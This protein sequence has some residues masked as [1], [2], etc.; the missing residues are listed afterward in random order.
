MNPETNWDD[1]EPL[2]DQ[3]LAALPDRYRV[4]IVLCDLEGRPRAEAA[5]ALRCSEGTLSSRLTRGRRLLADRLKRRGVRLSAGALTALLT[6]QSAALAEPLIRATLPV[7][8]S[9]G[10]PAG[11]SAAASVSPNV[12]HLATGVMKSMFLKKLQT[13][14]FAAF[15]VAALAVAGAVSFPGAEAAPVPKTPAAPPID[16][17]ALAEALAD[18][19]GNLLMHRKVFKE[20]KCDFDQFDK[21][22]D[23]LEDAQEKGAQ[24]TNEILN[25]IR[26][27]A[28]GAANPDAAEKLFQE[29]Q[30]AGEKEFRKAVAAVV[31]DILTPAQRQR[32]REIDLQVRGH[33]AFLSPAVA[34]AL[35]LNAKQKEQFEELAK[36]IEEQIT[37]EFERQPV[38]GP[39]GEVTPIDYDKVEREAGEAGLKRALEILTPE[40][41]AAWKKM[42]GVPFTLPANFHHFWPAGLGGGGGVG[43]AIP[44]KVAPGAAR[45]LPLVPPDAVPPAKPVK[46]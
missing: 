25:Q 10:A 15:A 2:L 39:N 28:A 7:A 5:Q 4:P 23:V 21:I 40:Q 30:E 45:D 36:K 34:K 9:A 13:A 19:D 41:R 33:E 29:A 11:T 18:V 42:T 26:G 24:K 17:K 16:E 27:N 3:E 31:K 22:M 6:E 20:L 1:V 12:A 8:L 46:P 44:G 37:R 14:A 43:R 38:P 32:L 35:E